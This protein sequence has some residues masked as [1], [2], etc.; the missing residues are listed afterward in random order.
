MHDVKLQVDKAHTIVFTEVKTTEEFPH[1]SR[2][3]M[4]LAKGGYFRAE[5]GKTVDLSNPKTAF[6]YRSDKK[7]YQVR[8]PLPKDVSIAS[9]V[10]LDL[11]QSNLRVIGQPKQMVWHK[12]P[13]IRVELDGRKQMT[14]ETKLF[15]F[16]DPKS[17]APIGVSANLGSVTQVRIYENLK[18][19]STIDPTKFQFTRPKGWKKVTPTTGGWN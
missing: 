19:N 8:D 1:D 10:G 5:T 17:H 15:V 6:T 2:T 12:M 3:H 4:W 9:L 18:L 7:I 16:L 13:A 11:F 14:K